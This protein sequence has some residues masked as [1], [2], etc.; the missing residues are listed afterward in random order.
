[1]DAPGHK[2]LKCSVHVNDKQ[3]LIL[4]IG[5]MNQKNEILNSCLI[6]IEDGKGHGLGSLE[7]FSKED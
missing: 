2:C 4:F 6:K 1:M 5:G 7:D 3:E